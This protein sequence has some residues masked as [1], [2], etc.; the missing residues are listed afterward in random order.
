MKTILLVGIHGA[1]G[2]AAAKLFAA[3]GAKCIGTSSQAASVPA[4]SR[5]IFYLDL[6]NHASI[7][8]LAK[9]VPSVDGIVFCAGF[10][11]RYSLMETS[12]THHQKMMDIHVSGP[13]FVVQALHKKI[14]KG[15]GIVFIS[16]VAAQKGSYDP[17]YAIA[18]AAIAG[19]TRTLARELA[20]LK[21]T[22]NAIAPGLVK[23]TPVHQ[24]MTEDFRENHIKSTPLRQLASTQDCAEAIFFLSTQKQITGQLVH[25]NGGQYFGN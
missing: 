20:P 2:K 6:Q 12:Q 16:S 10:E 1:I 5:E 15:A 14:K 21:I 22:V 7:T 25:I 8:A 18:K 9:Q 19:M 13:L 17:S 23:E 11:P 24:R 3:N 4:G